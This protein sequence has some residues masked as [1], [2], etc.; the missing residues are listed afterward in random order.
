MLLAALTCQSPVAPAA[1]H[2][3]PLRVDP[4]R[5]AIDH[6]HLGRATGERRAGPGYALRRSGSR[7]ECRLGDG[8]RSALG[9][10]V[11]G[12]R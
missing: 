12:P 4:A 2:A 3:D 8:G 11:T 5:F 6:E 10:G 7:L 9:Y 1:R